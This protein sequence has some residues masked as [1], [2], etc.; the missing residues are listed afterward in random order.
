MNKYLLLSAAAALAT[1]AAGSAQAGS[2][3]VHFLSTG[4][5]SYCD[6][7]I[8]TSNFSSNA[9]VGYHVYTHCSSA[10]PNLVTVGLGEKGAT[11]KKGKKKGHIDFSDIT[12]G[13]LY[14]ENAGILFD[15]AS[16]VQAGGNWDLWV[17]FSGSSAFL[18][19][20][21]V[22]AA[23][24]F[25]KHNGGAQKSTVSAIAAKFHLTRKGL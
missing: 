21:G 17:A 1:T 5:G 10:D 7:E 15:L 23:G 22:L 18:G 4:G 8:G 2:Y 24:Q 11:P 20:E 9:A 14:A 12:F 6:G 16:P 3:S 13:Y 19:N 25:A